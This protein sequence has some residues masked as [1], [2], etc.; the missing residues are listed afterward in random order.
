MSLSDCLYLLR[1]CVPCV[2]CVVIICCPVCDVMKKTQD[3]NVNILRTK[4]TLNMK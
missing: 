4:R 1:Y 2:L 3:K